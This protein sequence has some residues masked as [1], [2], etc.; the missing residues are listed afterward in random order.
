MDNSW[1]CLLELNDVKR[2]VS[3]ITVKLRRLRGREGRGQKM[4]TPCD[5]GTMLSSETAG[6]SV[7]PGSVM[8]MTGP[9]TLV[10]FLRS[11]YFQDP[12]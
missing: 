4:S 2:V 3:S 8:V 5:C 11:L 7:P 1:I 6:P 9:A 12:L 10:C